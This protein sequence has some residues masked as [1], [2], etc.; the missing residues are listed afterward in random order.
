MILLARIINLI[1][2]IAAGV[3]VAGIL[4]YVLGAN[5]SNGVVSAVMDAARWLT[6]PFDNLFNIHD[7]KVQLAVNWGIAAVVWLVVGSLVV[8]VLASFS[9]VGRRRVA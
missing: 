9:G 3:I 4:L 1:T 8:R 7:P 2:R 6:G 5:S